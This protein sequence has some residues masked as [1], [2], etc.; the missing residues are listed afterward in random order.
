MTHIMKIDEMA[1]RYADKIDTAKKN[2]DAQKEQKRK[3][4]VTEIDRIMDS[5]PKEDIVDVIDTYESI[6]DND[7]LSKLK[8][9]VNTYTMN[10][11]TKNDNRKGYVKIYVGD[12]GDMNP[13]TTWAVK[14]WE[15]VKGVTMD[16]EFHVD[17][18][19]DEDAFD[20]HFIYNKKHNEFDVYYTT[21]KIGTHPTHTVYRNGHFLPKTIWRHS[22]LLQNA[23]RYEKDGDYYYFNAD[24]RRFEKITI[25]AD[26]LIEIM[27][28]SVSW[29]SD[30]CRDFFKEVEALTNDI[31]S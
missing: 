12:E 21:D 4:L 26:C 1:V 19:S 7:L 30:F 15:T 20:T 23:I 16:I 22:Y 31:E 11:S 28:K 24:S 8:P 25:K 13:K 2:R 27:K 18:N 9:D 14:D 6:I 17:G 29:V 10:F 3:N 5:Y